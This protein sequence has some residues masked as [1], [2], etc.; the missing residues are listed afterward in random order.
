MRNK[1]RNSFIG[2]VLAFALVSASCTASDA[3]KA[4]QAAQDVA[5]SVNLFANAVN[6]LNKQGIITNHEALQVNSILE[7]LNAANSIF[8]KGVGDFK[9]GTI[10]KAQLAALFANSNLAL[11]DLNSKGILQ[12]SDPAARARLNSITAS[13]AVAFATVQG[14]LGS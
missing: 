2:I 13:I 3:K 4:A 14:I 12:I 8:T 9:N 1:F 7:E 6:D 5:T 10:T 11:Q